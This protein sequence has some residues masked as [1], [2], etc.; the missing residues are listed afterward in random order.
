[1]NLNDIFYFFKYDKSN[2]RFKIFRNKFNIF[3]FISERFY[4][5]IIIISIKMMI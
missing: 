5:W 1:M 2:E 3:K 4:D